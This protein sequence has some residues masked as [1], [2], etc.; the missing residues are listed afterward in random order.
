MHVHIQ[1]W[2][3]AIHSSDQPD[4][5][6]YNTQHPLEQDQHV[7]PPQG[8]GANGSMGYIEEDE[9]SAEDDQ[10]ESEES[11]EQEEGPHATL[12]G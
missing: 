12:S 11:E 7:A 5:Y 1:L 6:R 9:D 10:S 3:F 8:G 2:K 4:G